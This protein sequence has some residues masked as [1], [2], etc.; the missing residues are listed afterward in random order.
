[1]TGGSAPSL[2]TNIEGST[3]ISPSCRYQYVHIS[4]STPA[5]SSRRGSPSFSHSPAIQ[6]PTATTTCSGAIGPALVSTRVTAPEPSSSKPM[7]STPSSMV[8]P[9]SRALEA[10]PSIESRL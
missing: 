7:T 1:M 4:V 8:A 10:S 2:V 5:T 6:G 3:S 9:A